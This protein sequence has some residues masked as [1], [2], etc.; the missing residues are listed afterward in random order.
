MPKGIFILFSKVLPK[1]GGFRR[2][3]FL[4]SYRNNRNCRA[5]LATL[6]E[7][8]CTIYESVQSVVLTD[9]YVL[10]WVVLSATLTNDDVTSLSKLTTEKLKS[11]SF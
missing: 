4:F 6:L 10:A 8:Y 11:K 2:V 5:V 7:Y 3:F 1:Q 9:T